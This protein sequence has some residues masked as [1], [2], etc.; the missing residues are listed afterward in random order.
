[1]KYPTYV[2]RFGLLMLAGLSAPLSLMAD[3]YTEG[4]L[5]Y[6]YDTNSH[7]ASV[8]G[9]E[10]KDLTSAV[11]ASSVEG[12]Q[13]TSIADDVFENCTSL[14]SV[15]IPSTITNIAEN[16]FWGCTSLR[17]FTVNEANPNFSTTGDV[18]Y[19]KDQSQIVKVGSN[20]VCL[21]IP[22][23]VTSIGSFAFSNCT[24]L[25][26]ISLPTSVTSIAD[27]AFAYC[28]PLK[29]ISL[30]TSLTNIGTWAFAHCKALRSISMPASITSIPSSAFAYCSSLGQVTLSSETTSIADWAFAYC[31]SL[32]SISIPAAVASIGED[33]FKGCTAITAFTVDAANT[34]Y[35]AEGSV[36]F[37][38]EKTAIVKACA[39]TESLTIPSSVTSIGYGAFED[40]EALQTIDIPSTV[41]NIGSWAFAYN[42]ALTSVTL[43]STLTTTPSWTFAFSNALPTIDIPASVTS[44]GNGAFSGW[45][46]LNEISFES[47][48]TPTIEGDAFSNISSEAQIIVP[49][50]TLS[51]YQEALSGYD[52]SVIEKSVLQLQALYAKALTTT[53]R[54][55]SSLASLDETSSNILTDASQLSTNAQEPTEGAIANLIDGN[56]NTFF[57]STWSQSSTANAF[58]YLQIDLKDAYKNLLLNYYKRQ[59][60][61]SNSGEPVKVHVFATNNAEATDWTDCGYVNFTYNFDDG[62]SGKCPIALTDNYRYIRLQVEET[63]TNSRSNG[64]LYFYLSELG[65]SPITK[66]GKTDY[67]A[68]DGLITD[69]SQLSTNAQ[70]P[71]EGSLAALI[72]NDRSTFFHS[73]WSVAS[74]DNARHF[75]QVDL[76]AA[77]KQ[78]TLKYSRRE[79]KVDNSTPVTLH[80]YGT[81]TPDIA[82]SWTDLGTHTCTYAYDCGKT[83][84][85]PLDLGKG[86]RHVR[87]TVEATSQ[88]SSSNGNLYFYWSELHA[89]SRACKADFMADD[90]RTAYLAAI[91]T[92]E[93]EIAAGSATEATATALQSGYEAAEEATAG[94]TPCDFAKSFYLTA[95]SD[96][97]HVV[98]T[99]IDAAT[100]VANDQSIRNDYRY[101]AGSVIPAETGVLLRSGKGNSFFLTVG[102]TNETAPEDNLL[103]GTLTDELT[104]VDGA[105]KYYKLSYDKATGTQIGFYYGAEDGAA[106][107][108]KAGKAFLALP[109][110]LNAAQFAGFSLF[111]LDNNHGSTTAI[112]DATTDTDAPVVIYDLNG[113]RVNANSLNGLSKGIYIINGKKT[114][115]K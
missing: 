58:H 83:G 43:P 33:A 92:A 53:D 101:T 62:K 110:T 34:S 96:Q 19:N 30:S 98:P 88:N 71:R 111:D 20:V 104:D 81:D 115:K 3:N 87:L 27:W 21:S 73:T 10:S 61:A 35:A 84:I 76:K 26:S 12:C 74:T 93:Q 55:L 25:T 80:V 59:G 91:S 95:Y 65:V 67:T 57:H 89:Y 1:M 36:L 97:A 48:S 114:I 47:T 9:T 37:N 99:G 14:Q 85:L 50:G 45:T 6:A 2:K 77:Y 52:Y 39:N 56:T 72:D 78:I 109:A 79:V 112:T 22:S 107:V 86:Y 15:S 16:A 29:S 100:V 32:K 69:A 105:G 7:T 44:V 40:C 60:V 102:E 75:L 41:T 24:A 103:H 31:T 90:A 38:K 49:N 8:I 5:V 17:S 108:N 70:E 11:I 51:S 28:T 54:G 63:G 64:N 82:D 4:G 13:V 106:F 46:S 23:T 113:R 94:A 66:V 18:L 42:S 68:N